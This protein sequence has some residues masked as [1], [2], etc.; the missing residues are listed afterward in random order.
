MKKTSNTGGAIERA[1]ALL[2]ER[3]EMAGALAAAVEAHGQALEA[4]LGHGREV[5]V[6]AVRALYESDAALRRC[7]A[8][9]VLSACMKAARLRLPL[10]RKLRY[11][12]VAAEGG[13]PVFRL[14]ARGIVALCARAGGYRRI[15]AGRV[16]EGEL[17][18]VDKLTGEPDLSGVRVPGGRVEGYFAYFEMA[19]GYARSL[20]RTVDELAPAVGEAPG[21]ERSEARFDE[22]ALCAVLRE[23]LLCW[24]A[25]D[26]EL[27]MAFAL[28]DGVPPARCRAPAGCAAG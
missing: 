10:S 21:A 28:E 12:S 23:L 16:Y 27:E 19:N 4:C 15:N 5:F 13:R 24:G 3:G 18:G 20:Y 17:R 14:G 9:A 25:M 6:E 7:G 26:A 2:Q 1:A 8:E 11:V 22:A